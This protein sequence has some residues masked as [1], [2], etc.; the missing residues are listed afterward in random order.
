MPSI[1]TRELLTSELKLAQADR[2][3]ILMTSGSDTM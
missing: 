2:R 3:D 1:G